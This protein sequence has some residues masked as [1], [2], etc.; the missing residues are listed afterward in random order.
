MQRLTIIGNLGKDAEVK[1]FNGNK[2]IN[3]SVAVTE[4]W[5]DKNGQKQSKTNWYECSKWGNQTTIANYLK[6]GVKLLVE[7]TPE[8]RA[9]VSQDGTAK[10]V[11]GVNVRNMEILVF[12]ESEPQSQQQSQGSDLPF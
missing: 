1:D 6:K 9:Y 3:F 4:N 8:A 11:Q 12:A 7:G 2:C 5:K 10:S